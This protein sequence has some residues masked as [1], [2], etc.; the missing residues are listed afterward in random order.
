MVTFFGTVETKPASITT[1]IE[2]QTK[3][4]Y[5]LSSPVFFFITEKAHQLFS[6]MADRY[7]MYIIGYLKHNKNMN[8]LPLRD[9]VFCF[10]VRF[11]IYILNL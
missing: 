6:T 1:W 8:I 11:E 3:S 10:K 4:L 5:V 9:T 2:I 7:V